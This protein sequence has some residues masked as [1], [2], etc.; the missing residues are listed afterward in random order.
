MALQARRHPRGPLRSAT[1]ILFE[2]VL[3]WDKT[4][5]I[6]VTA[7]DD[8]EDYLIKAAD[9]PDFLSSRFLGTSR[10]GHNIML[11]N[12]TDE[13]PCRLWP[14]DFFPGRRVQ[15]PTRDGLRDSGA[16]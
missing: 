5:P 9:R 14:N 6:P 13:E 16:L 11:R 1:L 2:D 7:R 15:I 10:A 12:E 3:F 8:D 4:R